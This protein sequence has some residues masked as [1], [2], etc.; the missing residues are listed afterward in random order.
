MYGMTLGEKRF[1]KCHIPTPCWELRLVNRYLHRYATWAARWLSGVAMWGICG[2]IA[3]TIALSRDDLIA[4][5]VPLPGAAVC[6]NATGYILGYWSACAFG[7]GRIDSRAVS[8]EVGMQ[9]GGMATGLVF[10]ALQRRGC[11]A[12]GRRGSV[13]GCRGRGTRFL[14]APIAPTCPGVSRV[15]GG[16]PLSLRLADRLGS[17]EP[18]ACS[19]TSK[20][21]ILVSQESG[22]ASNL[23]STVPESYSFDHL[24]RLLRSVQPA[25]F[26]L[27]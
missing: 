25:P 16:K 3:I 26:L 18:L 1:T 12:L 10:D 27:G 23:L 22:R 21:R 17:T 13:G 9:Y 5:A 8:I 11:C 20:A 14:L 24:F 6:H 7:L 4:V 2:V 19:I 15:F